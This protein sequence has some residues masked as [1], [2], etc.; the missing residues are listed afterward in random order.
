[1]QAN[2]L[3]RVGQYLPNG[4]NLPTPNGRNLPTPKAAHSPAER[5]RSARTRRHLAAVSN[6]V[7]F[8]TPTTAQ[9]LRE[10]PYRALTRTQQTIV[11]Y[12]Y[13]HLQLAE[14]V[15]IAA[16]VIAEQTGCALRTVRRAFQPIHDSGLI[17]IFDQTGDR[18]EDV[19]NRYELGP[20]SGFL[21]DDGGDTA[22]VPALVG[23]SRRDEKKKNIEVGN[24][25][26]PDTTP[27]RK[28]KRHIS[29]KVVRPHAPELFD[30]VR[31][32]IE[33]AGRTLN[34]VDARTLLASCRVCPL[35]WADT[36]V[37][38]AESCAQQT[39]SIAL[40]ALIRQTVVDMLDDCGAQVPAEWEHLRRTEFERHEHRGRQPTQRPSRSPVG[41]PHPSR[42]TPT[43]TPVAEERPT[44]SP[45]SG[46]SESW[47]SALNTGAQPDP[48]ELVSLISAGMSM[49]GKP[50]NTESPEERRTRLRAQVSR[51]P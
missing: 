19:A 1:M 28:T 14:N 21:F 12:L 32:A 30:R 3:H 10:E 18:G 4:R 5:T 26:A 2:S 8:I 47:R 42:G 11:G 16:V 46:W 48:S 37:Q 15:E 43:A 25:E 45:P 39:W 50:T 20:A 41:H 49:P 22:A 34:D 6:G 13:A 36:M 33:A 7:R 51:I 40:G 35:E 31:Y 23:S 17:S 44:G 27:V 29:G 24:R 38:V 9:L